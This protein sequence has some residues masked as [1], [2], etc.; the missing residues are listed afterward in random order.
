MLN[1]KKKN[2]YIQLMFWFVKT[3]LIFSRT[4][5]QNWIITCQCCLRIWQRGEGVGVR[6]FK[7][8]GGGDRI[9]LLALC[10]GG[11]GGSGSVPLLQ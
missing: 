4:S 1:N 9:F 7:V 8:R 11:C 2:I 6:G 5:K 10:E 3:T